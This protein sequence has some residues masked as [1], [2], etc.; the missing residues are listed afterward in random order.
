MQG[1]ARSDGQSRPRGHSVPRVL[2][3]HTHFTDGE[4]ETLALPKGVPSPNGRAGMHTQALL[5][6][7]PRGLGLQPS[8]TCDACRALQAL[9]PPCEGDA[10]VHLKALSHPLDSLGDSDLGELDS[11]NAQLNQGPPSPPEALMSLD[12]L[13]ICLLILTKYQATRARLRLAD[14]GVSGTS[15]VSR[16]VGVSSSSPESPRAS[17]PP[18]VFSWRRAALNSRVSLH[19]AAVPSD[20]C[21]LVSQK[22]QRKSPRSPALHS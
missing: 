5:Q 20:T 11:L 22:G 19:P 9:C 1:Q 4:I 14:Q 17:E 2:H 12:N 3:S 7:E 16:H 10:C 15:G 21:H 8:W 6:G 13:A 18:G